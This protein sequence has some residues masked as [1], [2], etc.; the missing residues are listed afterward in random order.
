M[1]KALR[2]SEK[3]KRIVSKYYKIIIFKEV[4]Y[5]FLP[6]CIV[7]ADLADPEASFKK[8]QQELKQKGFQIKLEALSEKDIKS[9]DI[10]ENLTQINLYFINFIPKELS[11]SEEK[12]KKYSKIQ[13]GLALITGFMVVL[14]GIFYV[15]FIEPYYGPLY[16]STIETHTVIFFF[17]IGM[18]AIIVVHEF[19][20][21]IFSKRHHLE[22]SHPFLIPGPP[23]LGMFGAFVSIRDDPQTR[24]QQFDVAVGGIIFGFIIAFLLVLIGFFFS[25][26]MNTEDYIAI[27][28]M[29]SDKTYSEAAEFIRDRL[30]NYN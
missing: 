17:C 13:V 8:T 5:S 19:G 15:N 11:I 18:L 9:Y 26:F 10:D 16:R 20:H 29:Q 30:N 2:V 6:I 3:I 27:R 12:K 28:M 14:S 7:E 22:C 21:V 25:E 4:P 24:N 23:P 1:S